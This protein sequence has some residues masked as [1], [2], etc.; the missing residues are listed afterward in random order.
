MRT[1][2]VCDF[3]VVTNRVVCVFVHRVFKIGSTC[4]PFKVLDVSTV[5]LPSGVTWTETQDHSKWGV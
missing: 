2:Y 4:K 3:C 1:V 5:T